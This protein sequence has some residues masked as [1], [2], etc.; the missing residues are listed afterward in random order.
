M[1]LTFDKQINLTTYDGNPVPKVVSQLGIIH[2]S[3]N[4]DLTQYYINNALHNEGD[5]ATVALGYPVEKKDSNGHKYIEYEYTDYDQLEWGKQN[6]RITR[7]RID[8]IGVKAFPNTGAIA[9]YKLAYQNLSK[10]VAPVN[11]KTKKTKAP[12]LAA[13]TNEDGTITF[14]ITPPGEGSDNIHYM[15]YRITMQLDI[16]R[17]EYIT[18]E[19]TVTIPKPLVTGTYI[20]Y[21]TGY[22]NEGEIVSDDSNSIELVLQGEYAEWPAV[23]PGA[24]IPQKLVDLLDVSIK[25]LLDQQIIQYNAESQK[26]ENIPN[27]VHDVLEGSS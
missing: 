7:R 15:C 20:A 12:T 8:R 9:H 11:Y 23:T 5:K 13:T 4:G 26:F 2:E 3:Q 22:V 21:A 25:N 18:Y 24:E 17:L 1:L 6:S 16:N 19:E 10:V 14:T 27:F